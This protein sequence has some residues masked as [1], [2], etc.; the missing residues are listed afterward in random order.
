MVC[1][2]IVFLGSLLVEIYLYFGRVRLGLR[3]ELRWHG[4]ETVCSFIFC[5]KYRPTAWNRDA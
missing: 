4:S 5:R 2:E 1:V 3:L